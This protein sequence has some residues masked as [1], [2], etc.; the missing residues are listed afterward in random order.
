MQKNK[1]DT[2]VANCK[3]QKKKLQRVRNC[4]YKN[5]WLVVYGNTGTNNDLLPW[6]KRTKPRPVFDRI[7][8]AV[9][10]YV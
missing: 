5:K 6:R 8:Y 4:K 9:V 3:Y 2:L 1:K 10:W 7:T